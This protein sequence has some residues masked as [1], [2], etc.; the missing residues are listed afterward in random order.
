MV[1]LKLPSS[2]TMFN[3][4]PAET[5]ITYL[6]ECANRYTQQDYTIEVDQTGKTVIY[7]NPQSIGSVNCHFLKRVWDASFRLNE[8]TLANLDPQDPIKSVADNLWVRSATLAVLGGRIAGP[9]VGITSVR[10][11]RQKAY[12]CMHNPD[13]LLRLTEVQDLV[14]VWRADQQFQAYA[15]PQEHMI[16]DDNRTWWEAS[17]T[18]KAADRAL[19]ENQNLELGEVV[20]WTL[21]DIVGMCILHDMFH[22]AEQ[23][24]TRIDSVGY[25]CMAVLFP[26]PP[27]TSRSIAKTS[28]KTSRDKKY[29]QGW[30]DW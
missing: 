30:S 26:P 2:A 10:V 15:E 14:L 17:I 13:L 8:T 6:I 29:T 1:G 19:A 7:N 28:S 24:V 5:R 25:G 9:E 12:T 18:S 21:D 22:L 11:R 3:E 27:S 16:K 23:V 4:T 20:N